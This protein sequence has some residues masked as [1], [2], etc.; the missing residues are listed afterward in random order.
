MSPEYQGQRRP[1]SPG[2]LPERKF[3]RP[4]SSFGAMMVTL[5]EAYA[6]QSSG[7]FLQAV[8]D[9][10][11]LVH[12]QFG[13]WTVDLSKHAVGLEAHH[14]SLYNAILRLA[15]CRTRFWTWTRRSSF[16]EVLVQW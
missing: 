11:A 13:L 5:D 1:M 6:K 8:R 12:A 2:Q 4:S 10:L 7:E 3:A 14:S 15:S 16:F 9:A